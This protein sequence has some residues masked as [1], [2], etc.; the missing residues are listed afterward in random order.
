MDGVCVK[1]IVHEGHLQPSIGDRSKSE[2]TQWVDVLLPKGDLRVF[3]DCVGFSLNGEDAFFPFQDAASRDHVTADLEPILPHLITLWRITHWRDPTALEDPLS[4][5]LREVPWYLSGDVL[6]AFPHNV[7]SQHPYVSFDMWLRTCLYHA[8]PPDGPRIEFPTLAH[9]QCFNGDHFERGVIKDLD[10]VRTILISFL[11]SG[12]KGRFDA[13]FSAVVRAEGFPTK[14]QEF[15]IF[16]TWLEKM[17]GYERWFFLDELA[18]R[19]NSAYEPSSSVS[20]D[21]SQCSF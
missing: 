18:P 3:H 11:D 2:K 9:P 1:G 5:P 16:S 13:Q 8:Q 19:D 4:Q 17:L 10:L 21:P 12:R 14:A 7:N 6:Y 20:V 15:E